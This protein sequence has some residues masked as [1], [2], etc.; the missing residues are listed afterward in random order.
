MHSVKMLAGA[1]F[2]TA[3]LCS[4]SAWSAAPVVY[5]G[6][7]ANATTALR[8]SRRNRGRQ[9]YRRAPK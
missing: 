4:P 3:I 9:E 6:S 7:G 5:S 8:F 1:T 2:A